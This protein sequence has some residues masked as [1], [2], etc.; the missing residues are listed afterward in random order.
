[1]R[2]TRTPVYVTKLTPS[3]LRAISS[4]SRY[5]RRSAAVFRISRNLAHLAVLLLPGVATHAQ[6]TRSFP[7][8]L[9][10]AA[11][12]RTNH[13]VTYNG[14]YRSIDF[15]GGDVPDNIGVCTDLIIRAYRGI[16]VDL[17][18]LIHLDMKSSFSEYPRDW[19][20]GRPDPNID[21]RRVPN[22]QTFLSRH[23]QELPVTD[24]GQDYEP[25]DLVTWMLPGNLPHIGIVVD[26][27]TLDGGRH[28]VV[29]NIGSGPRIEDILFVYKI[30]GHYRYPG[31]E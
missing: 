2:C 31:P 25:G 27:T 22:L 18:E 23:G 11:I 7:A 29:H 19:G 9:I 8:A 21:H 15:P 4:V 10:G 30:T 16:G 24:N 20:L 1:M 5:L 12:E 14:S 17:Q 13:T 28:L 3:N 6:E 26:R